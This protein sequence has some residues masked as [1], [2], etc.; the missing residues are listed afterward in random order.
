[1]ALCPT[2]RSYVFTAKF[3]H[4]LGR[5][6]RMGRAEQAGVIGREPHRERPARAAD[7]RVENPK[8]GHDTAG[9]HVYRAWGDMYRQSMAFVEG[10]EKGLLFLAGSGKFS[11]GR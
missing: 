4:D 8:V 2:A 9:S 10:E 1:M 5:F 6:Q 3:A 11:H 7:E